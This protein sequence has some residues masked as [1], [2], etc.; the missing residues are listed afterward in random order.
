MLIDGLF[1]QTL[2]VY[3]GID[4]QLGVLDMTAVISVSGHEGLFRL[5]L[6]SEFEGMRGT[7]N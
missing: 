4:N 1:F 2:Q 6:S 7:I 3:C 5:S